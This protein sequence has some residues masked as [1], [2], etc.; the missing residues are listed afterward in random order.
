MNPNLEEDEDSTITKPKQSTLSKSQKRKQ[1]RNLDA[2]GEV[3]RGSDWVDIVSHVNFSIVIKEIIIKTS[4]M[5]IVLDEDLTEDSSSVR[6]SFLDEIGNQKHTP[7]TTRDKIMYMFKRPAKYLQEKF[8]PGS[9]KSSIFNILASTMGAGILTLPYAINLAGLYF[10]IVLIIIGM[11]FSLYTSQL[12]IIVAE[13]LGIHSYQIIG[14]KLFGNKMRVFTNINL[15][16]N[17]YGSAIAFLVL[18]KSLIPLILSKLGTDNEVLTNEYFWGSMVSLFIIFPL[19]LYKQITSLRYTSA[20]CFISLIYLAAS[21]IVGFFSMTNTPSSKISGAPGMKFSFE[22]FEVFPII[23]FVFNSHPYVLPVYDELQRKN[24]KRGFKFISRS[25]MIALSLYLLIGI[26]GY[27]TFYNEY[28]TVNFPG[29]IL[30]ADY[31]EGN[32]PIIIV[33]FI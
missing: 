18:L 27:L 24:T 32:V 1:Y 11:I 25:L 13:T 21:M 28:S 12:L 20:I 19:C 22:V 4:N 16:I 30:K 23:I 2:N 33:K 3:L 26:F 8:S 5:S 9:L 14:D 10:G 15:I 17:N 6:N 31:E 29:E 7:L